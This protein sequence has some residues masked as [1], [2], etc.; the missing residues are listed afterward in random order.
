[1]SI[2]TIKLIIILANPI[3][4]VL[5]GVWSI[6]FGKRRGVSFFLI[7]GI[8]SCLAAPIHLVAGILVLAF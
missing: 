3:A 5:A 7:T 6:K 4:M 1:M 2:D 8:L